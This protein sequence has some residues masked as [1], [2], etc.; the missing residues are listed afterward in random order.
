MII[1]FTGKMGVG[2]STAIEELVEI[3]NKEIKL[4]KFAAPL[5]DMQEYIY[6]RIAPVY[7]RG[8]DF[9]KDRKLLQYL[10]FEW[11]RQTIGET[12]WVDLWKSE[13]LRVL[14]RGPKY[15][16][17]CDDVRFDNEAEAVKSLGGFVIQVTSSKTQDRIKMVG[18]GHPSESGIN[19]KY[20]DYI[21]TND[22]TIKELRDSLTDV[23]NRIEKT[24]YINKE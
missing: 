23:L 22:G 21:I 15:L 24:R 4:I 10:G 16:P 14:N 5:Y 8:E 20:I 1:A 13:V 6:R 2:K 11:G 17:V 18:A 3:C 9:I 7:T 12:V 19:K